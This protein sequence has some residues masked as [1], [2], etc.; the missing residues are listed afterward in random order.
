MFKKLED[1]SEFIENHPLVTKTIDLLK[2]KSLPGF[3]GVSIMKIG[4]FIYR[5]TQR[6]D[7]MTRANSM[8]FS[9]FIS[10]FP[11][12]II[13][14]S[15]VSF[16]PIEN[17]QN[18][19]SD[20][21]MD[22]LPYQAYVFIMDL[23]GDVFSRDRVD[24]LSI[25]FVLAIYFASNGMEAMMRGFDKNY[26][27]TFRKRGWLQR[28]AAAVRL[29]FLIGFLCVLALILIFGS[30]ILFAWLQANTIVGGWEFFSYKLIRW[31][32][33]L[34]L[35]YSIIANIYHFAPPTK[36]RFGFFSIGTNFATLLSLLSSVLFSWFV[37][38]FGNYDNFYGPLGT[39]VMVMLWLQINCFI[40]L[41]GFELNAGIAVHRD[42]SDQRRNKSVLAAAKAK[43]EEES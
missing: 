41:A 25:G 36:K 43:E 39:L 23:L 22:L 10:L 26:D 7:I 27:F 17:I 24:L 34:L 1:I 18:M 29:T 14:F 13:L 30:G 4:S 37:N 6:D 33:I 16:V 28:R 3:K 40:L 8:A 35:I 38:Q 2:Q 31:L 9:F 19:V 42:I 20:L 32:F 5:E 11:F 21:I 15:I 12:M